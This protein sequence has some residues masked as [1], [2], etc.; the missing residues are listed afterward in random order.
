[1]LKLED[2]KHTTEKALEELRKLVDSFEFADDVETITSPEFMLI[3]D[4][5]KSQE[6]V[7]S[8]EGWW[9]IKDGEID[10]I[11]HTEEFCGIKNIIQK[12]NSSWY[13]INKME[14]QGAVNALESLIQKYNELSKK[15]DAEIEN[16]LNF[17]QGLKKA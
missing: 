13:R 16:F 3:A 8:T 14:F 6:Y 7:W 4:I 1:M 15:K 17:C 5:C 2:R 9:R 10:L 12:N 11:G